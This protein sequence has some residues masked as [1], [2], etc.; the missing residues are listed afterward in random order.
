MFMKEKEFTFRGHLCLMFDLMDEDLFEFMMRR[1]DM[2]VPMNDIKEIGASILR[3]LKFISE[4]EVVHGDLKP[5]NI[6][7]KYE[8]NKVED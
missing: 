6:L 3:N 5:E 1:E 4:N 8:N 2:K 7:V